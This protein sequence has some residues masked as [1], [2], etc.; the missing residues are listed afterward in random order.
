[1]G[2]TSG[3]DEETT[4]ALLLIMD[5]PKN[6]LDRLSCSILNKGAGIDDDYFSLR[7]IRSKEMSFSGKK[8]EDHFG[9]D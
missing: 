4:T 2:K 3:D 5:Q 9:I 1:L 6:G 8:A 7:R